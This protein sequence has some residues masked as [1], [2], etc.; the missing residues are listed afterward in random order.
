MK[1]KIFTELCDSINN[2]NNIQ[3]YSEKEGAQMLQMITKCMFSFLK[4]IVKLGKYKDS[5]I[6]LYTLGPCIETIAKSN[7]TN[8]S[9]SF[10]YNLI[11]C[12]FFFYSDIH[13][14]SNLRYIEES[15]LLD[16]F[17]VMNT[18][19]IRYIQTQFC[20]EAEKNHPDLY[21]NKK[22]NLL[23]LMRNYYVETVY[24]DNNDSYY[25]ADL[26]LGMFEVVWCLNQSVDEIFSEACLTVKWLYKFNYNLWKI[27]NIKSKKLINN[28]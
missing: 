2:Y 22:G 28:T 18:Y 16:F 7:K 15:F 14:G 12:E 5:F 4:E 13:N 17:R 20:S 9:Y 26:S 19:K 1:S 23:P 8:T 6:Y 11:S 24:Q 27:E 21:R 3:N 25:K 10:S